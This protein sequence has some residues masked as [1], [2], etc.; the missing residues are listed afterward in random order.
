M[1]LR[2]EFRLSVLPLLRRSGSEGDATSCARSAWP[3]LLGGHHIDALHKH[4]LVRVSRC[5]GVGDA[6][7]IVS[8]E[9]GARRGFGR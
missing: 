1:G 8:R 5:G 9:L 6:L 2:A 7:V 3:C 4:D